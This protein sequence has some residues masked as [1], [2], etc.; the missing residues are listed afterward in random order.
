MSSK[1]EDMRSGVVKGNKYGLRLLPH[2]KMA[3]HEMT[4]RV[5]MNIADV[6]GAMERLNGRVYKG[7][8]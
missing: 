8:K 7:K 6:A 3:Q 4:K 5:Y 2:R 1:D